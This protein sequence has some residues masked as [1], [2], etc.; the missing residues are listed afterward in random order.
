[1]D[2]TNWNLSALY[3]TEQELETASQEAFKRALEFEKRY[4]GVLKKLSADEFYDG[5]KEYESIS[6]LLGRIMTYAFL[7]FAQD[8]NNGTFYAKYQ[9]AYT[10][11]SEHLLFFE[12]EFNTLP[13]NSQ[14]RFIA[15]SKKYAYFLDE[16]TKAKA[17]QL[18][19]KV[20]SVILKKE[21]TGS[22][23][24]ARL[25]DEY[26]SVLKFGYKGKKLSEEEILSLLHSP[27]R[28]TRKAAA[29]AFTKELKKHQHLLGFIY[30][31][32]RRDLKTEC[33]IRKY[34]S[35]EEFRHKENK[36]SQKSVD[37]LVRTSEE[38]F[39]IVH[40]YYEKKRE[41]LGYD[42]L[43]DYDR[44]APLSGADEVFEYERSREIVLET[45]GAF[46]PVFADIAKKAFDEGWIDVYPKSSKRGGAFSH[47][48]TPDAHPYVLLN[49]TNQRR[50]LFT[51][52]H[53]L[54]HAVHQYLSKDV[55]F[56]LS[57]TPL[58]TAETASV[59]AEML[60]FDEM[61]KTAGKEAKKAMLS[62][63]L[64]DIFAT[65]Y[66]QI[67]FTTYERAVHAKEDELTLGEFNKL[68]LEQSVKM[69]GKSVKLTSGYKIWWS[70]IPHFIHT[71]FYCYAYAYG[72]LLV[73]A[74]FG[75]YKSGAMSDFREKYIEFLSAG[76]SRSPKELVALFG[77][78]IED[79]K[80]WRIGLDEIKKLVDEFKEL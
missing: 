5:L 56:L 65:L 20:E 29:A 14:K 64:E 43:Y 31:M 50:D 23:A 1:M 6:Q 49:H 80:F 39:Y 72:Q 79:E 13:P 57:D 25:F 59:F 68:W 30:N 41:I 37:A 33:E 76:G 21:Q 22:D 7:K 40:E 3:D 32:I 28:S 36:I 45:F 47:P 44:Y 46:S 9:N 78:D 71:P 63:K 48:A 34:K 35:A 2:S 10:N 53:E 75:L 4:K 77:F 12:L 54:G 16:L 60:V 62:S 24:F 8:S 18:S 66:R 52:A 38:S 11:S 15:A 74:L 58:T 69:F 55:G 67:N 70:Y 51:L 17:H 73:L 19:L 61:K 27:E 42:E 26:F